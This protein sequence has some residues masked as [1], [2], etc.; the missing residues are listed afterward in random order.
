M[1]VMLTPPGGVGEKSDGWNTHC[2]LL[3]LELERGKELAVLL[4][5]E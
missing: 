5:G 2:T 4:E 3:L 1:V